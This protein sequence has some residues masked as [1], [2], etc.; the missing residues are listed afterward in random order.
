MKRVTVEMLTQSTRC[1][2][3]TL[4]S[5]CL[6][7]AGAPQLPFLAGCQMIDLCFQQHEWCLDPLSIILKELVIVM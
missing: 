3:W 1:C 7:S 5:F 4:L 2:R 6:V